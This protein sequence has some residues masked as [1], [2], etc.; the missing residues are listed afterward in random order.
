MLIVVK[1]SQHFRNQNV[2]P[3]L[4]PIAARSFL[5]YILRRSNLSRPKLD[6][7]LEAFAEGWI[8]SSTDLRIAA[9]LT[10]QHTE[11]N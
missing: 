8:T 2:P 4:I 9:E 7:A 3:D 6:L 11:Q 5:A 1:A 10:R